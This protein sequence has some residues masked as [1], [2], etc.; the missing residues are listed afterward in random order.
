MQL[1]HDTLLEQLQAAFPSKPIHPDS[2]FDQWGTTY[3]D[4]EPYMEQIDGKRWDQLDRAYIV[5]RADALGF[6]GTR[7]LAAVLPVYLRAMIEEGVW[8]PATGMLMLILAKPV[9]GENTG[10]GS[11]RFD[12]LVGTLTAEQRA[13]VASALHAF[14]EQDADGSLG[15]AARAALD[16][17]WKTYL[18]AGT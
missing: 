7:H 5:R 17:Y 18:P 13:V 1:E 8:S 14:A 15:R 11:E 12:A 10:L 16:G 3:P 4:A 9:P 6:L 2:A